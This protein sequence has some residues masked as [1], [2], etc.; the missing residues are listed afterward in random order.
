[1]I[2]EAR[3]SEGWVS[4]L[5]LASK[6]EF[7]SLCRRAIN[8]LGSLATP[9][10]RVI[11]GRKYNIPEL[12]LPAYVDLCQSTAPLTEEDGERLGLQ[13]VIKIYRVRQEWG[14]QELE[15]LLAKVRIHFSPVTLPPPPSYGDPNSLPPQ[16]S[17]IRLPSPSNKL[18]EESNAPNP[19]VEVL[20]T[21]PPQ[22]PQPA[23]PIFALTQT[24]DCSAVPLPM[25]TGLP[26]S[27]VS[28]SKKATLRDVNGTEVNIES[29]KTNPAP[30]TLITTQ[31]LPVTPTRKTGT[32]RIETPEQRQKRLEAEEQKEKFKAEAE[33]KARKEGKMNRDDEARK[34]KEV[35]VQRPDW[36]AEPLPIITMATTLTRKPSLLLT[37][38]R[39]LKDLSSVT[40]PLWI[41]PPN[42]EL[43]A[44]AREGKFRYDREFLLQFRS[45]CKE[46]LDLL[47]L[48]D[49]IALKPI[50]QPSLIRD[51][52]GRSQQLSSPSASSRPVPIGSGLP[53]A[54]LRSQ[55]QSMG[56]FTT[57]GKFGPGLERFEPA[58]ACS[59]SMGGP[60]VPFGSPP[61]QLIANQGGLN[62]S[63]RKHRTRSQRGEK[64]S[65]VVTLQATEY[66]W[67]R[68]FFASHDPESPEV[69]DRKVKALLNK[70]TMEKFDSISDQ[71]IQ[72]ANR[73]EHQKDGRTLVQVIRLVFEKAADE[74]TWSEMYARLCR[75]MMEQISPKVQDE[76][77]KSAK[78]KPIAGGQLFRKYLLNRCQEDF[79]RGWVAKEA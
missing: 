46:N 43:S 31:N 41:S 69:V 68:K 24:L 25:A 16:I 33:E 36:E 66:R 37:L 23:R 19:L 35:S 39:P 76:G 67:E 65:N 47:P 40:Y 78:G 21:T 79:E 62:E 14:G 38:A 8:E 34:K 18:S 60:S 6:W 75:K 54:T 72:W 20:P 10:E 7:Q 42:A 50:D 48:F 55:Y 3:S 30:P 52:S 12:R 71:I 51:S 53:G 5:E 49:V 73:S 70:L 77:I 1:M 2:E 11:L 13:D 45:I 64:R 29:L 56:Q 4:I 74:T 15:D 63:R 27:G 44:G 57:P 26:A 59:V 9:I 61:L 22:M 32:I 17:S 58:G 28:A